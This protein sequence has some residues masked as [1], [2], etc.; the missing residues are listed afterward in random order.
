MIDEYTGYTIDYAEETYFELTGK[1]RVGMGEVDTV[2]YPR[3]DIPKPERREPTRILRPMTREYWRQW[4]F[5][6]T[7]PELRDRLFYAHKYR[8]LFQQA[9]RW[10]EKE[11]SYPNEDYHKLL[12]IAQFYEDRENAIER[13]RDRLQKLEKERELE[14][15]RNSPEGIA[16]REFWRASAERERRFC[17]TFGYFSETKYHLA[18]HHR[19]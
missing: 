19:G 3:T 8:L 7:P 1:I 12:D 6:K 4:S 5:N 18:Q 13:E 15:W 2:S 14:Q 16:E 10:A 17:D 11:G 9:Y